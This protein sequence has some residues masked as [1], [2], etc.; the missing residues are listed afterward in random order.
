MKVNKI[1]LAILVLGCGNAMAAGH[2]FDARNDGM[3]GVGVAS[4]HYST[5]AVANPAL[6]AKFDGNDD[7]A[8]VLPT[9]GAQASDPD[10]LVDDI[11]QIKDSFDAFN[12][13]VSSGGDAA[14]YADTL[15]QQ[16]QQA[17]GKTG[18]AS[19][20]ANI[21]ATLPTSFATVGVFGNAYASGMVG[22]EMSQDDI[23][24]LNGVA[25]G[26]VTADPSRELTSQAVG[27]VALIQDYG[28]AFAHQFDVQGMPL[29][30]GLAPKAQKVETYNYSATI[31]DYDRSD[32]SDDKYLSSDSGFNADLGFALD[33]GAM[34]YGLNVRNLVSRDIETKN[35]AGSQYTYQI[36]PVATAGAA[37]RGEWVTAAADLDLN[38]TKGFKGQEESQ[39]GSIGLEFD[40]AKWA[41]LRVGYRAD[42]TGD[43]PNMATA[44]IGLSPFDVFHLDIAGQYGSDKAVGAMAGMRW[45]F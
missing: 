15:S 4:S 8:L 6:L 20:G 10:N 32:L 7:F 35:V 31:T 39:F 29:Y 36:A 16:L 11:D 2:Y 18:I 12:S 22:A 24:Y 25:N 21:Q 17:D 13:A 38:K 30:V 33:A 34:T 40:A 27:V 45:T 41:Q 9:V 42:L 3:G 19:V 44:G 23:D 37:Y 14:G 28:V 5:A 43:M 1:T 26:T